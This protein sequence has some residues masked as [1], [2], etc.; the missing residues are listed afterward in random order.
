MGGASYSNR[1][2]KLLQPLEQNA[3]GVWSKFFNKRFGETQKVCTFAGRLSAI[4]NNIE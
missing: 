1:W 4:G 3:P 2:S